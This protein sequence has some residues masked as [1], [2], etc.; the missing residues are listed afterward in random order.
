MSISANY[1]KKTRHLFEY[2]FVIVF[3]AAIII[4][5]FAGYSNLEK[6]TNNENLAFTKES[7]KK[8]ALLCYSIEG[9]FPPDIDYLKDNYNLIVNEDRYIIGYDTFAAN[10]MPE[11]TVYVR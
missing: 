8:A 5:F 2:F 7:I 3:F 10:V 11:I 1:K 6:S 4:W 9:S